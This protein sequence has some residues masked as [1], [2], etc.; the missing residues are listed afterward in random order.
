MWFSHNCV[1]N[2]HGNMNVAFRW[3]DLFEKA[4]A[5]IARSSRVNSLNESRIHSLKG[6]IVW[7]SIWPSSRICHRETGLE[8][9]CCWLERWNLYLLTGR[10]AAEHWITSLNRMRLLDEER[11][12][13]VR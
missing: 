12:S 8:R 2:N 7:Q 11:G 10:I 6:L 5:A 13:S 1:Q 3:Y 4:N 9:R